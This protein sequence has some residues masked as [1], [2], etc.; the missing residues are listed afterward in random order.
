MFVPWCRRLGELKSSGSS[1][2]KGDSFESLL[3]S[4]EALLLNKPSNFQT[5]KGPAGGGGRNNEKAEQK[6]GLE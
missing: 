3:L 1:T 4:F 6:K 5:P 2:Q